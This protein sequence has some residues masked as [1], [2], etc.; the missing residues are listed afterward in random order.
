VIE[1]F[2]QIMTKVHVLLEMRKIAEKEEQEL[3]VRQ[4]EANAA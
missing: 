3:K 2:E 4:A 1:Q